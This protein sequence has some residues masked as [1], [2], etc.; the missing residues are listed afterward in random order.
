MAE[1]KQSK[2]RLDEFTGK[3]VPDPAKPG[4]VSCL[5][6]F[7][8]A[9][10][11]PAQTRVYWDASLSSYVDIANTDIL[12]TEPIPK[13][14]SPL[15]GSYLWVSSSAEVTAGTTSGPSTKGKFFEGPL[16]ST[17]GSA[18]GTAHGGPSAAA[19]PA[20]AGSYARG[21]WY[22]WDACPTMYGGCGPH[23]TP[24]CPMVEHAP[25]AQAAAA[26]GI[27][28]RSLDCSIPTCFPFTWLVCYAGFGQVPTL[29]CPQGEHAM[30]TQACPPNVAEGAG[31]AIAGSYARGCWYSWD[32]CPTMYGCGPHRT[33]GCPMVEHAAGVGPAI[34]GSYARGC[35]YSWDA[36]PTMYGGCGPHRTPGCPMVEHAAAAGPA[37]AGSYARGCWYSFDACPTMFGCGPHRTPGCPI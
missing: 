37:I 32:A 35:W 5:Q 7:L 30:A 24:G 21:C 4:K 9:S 23:R 11:D 19:A 27:V 36:C 3:V 17:Y 33:P 25:G 1:S 8:G 13:D 14:Q 12:H 26:P 29:A 20:L 16:T 31:P 10:P 2:I 22:S 34:A 18:F 15:G 28:P 6:G